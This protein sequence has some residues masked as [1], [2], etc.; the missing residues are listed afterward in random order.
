MDDGILWISGG[1]QLVR[2]DQHDRTGKLLEGLVADDVAVGGAGV[3]VTDE[4]SNTITPIDPRTDEPGDP[5]EVQT[6]VDHLVVGDATLWVLNDGGVVTPVD[7][8]TGVVKPV[9]PTPANSSASTR[10][11]SKRK[12]DVGAPVTV[13]VQEPGPGAL[14]LLARGSA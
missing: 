10:R 12:R 8:S 14:W 4:L 3:W 9:D 13:A 11:R 2:I 1:S 5:I 7:P 6:G